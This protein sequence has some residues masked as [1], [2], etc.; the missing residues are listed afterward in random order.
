MHRIHDIQSRG[1]T[2]ADPNKDIQEKVYIEE[3]AV[4]GYLSPT[5]M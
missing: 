2:L 3:G 1:F 5:L 4:L